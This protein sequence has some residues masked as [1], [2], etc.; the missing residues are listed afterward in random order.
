MKDGC[1]SKLTITESTHGDFQYKKGI[2]ALPVFFADKRYRF[3]DNIIC[4]NTELVKAT[5]L[6]VY[7]IATQWLNT[8]H[9][10]INTVGPHVLAV[11]SAYPVML[12]MVEK[13]HIFDVN[14]QKQLLSDYDLNLKT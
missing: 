4:T 14:L 7:P 2:D 3:L 12:Q 8:Y 1:L 9:V 13:T 11:N 5:F 10:Q 6:M